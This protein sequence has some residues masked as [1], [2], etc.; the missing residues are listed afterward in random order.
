L[1][2]AQIDFAIHFLYRHGCARVGSGRHIFD[3]CKAFASD[4]NT[5]E[6]PDIRGVNVAGST[7]RQRLR[8]KCDN[9]FALISVYAYELAVV[10]C[11]KV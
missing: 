5:I 3:C 7:S 2:T 10:F 8:I 1:G 4:V 9:E 11:S 6:F